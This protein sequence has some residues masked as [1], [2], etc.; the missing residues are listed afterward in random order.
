MSTVQSESYAS[1]L[2]T[3][4]AEGRS[5]FDS[6]DINTMLFPTIQ[7]VSLLAS[8]ECDGFVLYPVKNNIF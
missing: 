7:M 8:G 3:I 5:N 4:V 6:A 2:A 1:Q